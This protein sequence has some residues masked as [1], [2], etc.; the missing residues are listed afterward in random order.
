MCKGDVSERE[1]KELYDK[2]IEQNMVYIEVE[3]RQSES[4]WKDTREMIGN[5]NIIEKTEKKW[6]NMQ[7]LEK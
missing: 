4:F 7:R 6:I 3:E 1:N 5:T 2:K